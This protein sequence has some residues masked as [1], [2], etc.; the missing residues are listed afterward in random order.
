MHL[1]DNNAMIHDN[2]DDNFDRLYKVRPV[3]DHFNAV[4]SS[5]IPFARD[6]SVDENICATK[7]KHTIRQYNPKKPHKWGFKLYMLCGTVGFIYNS[8]IHS[9]QENESRFR[10]PNECDLGASSNVV[11]RMVRPVP[12]RR[13]HRFFL[14]TILAVCL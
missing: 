3:I 2:N 7:L 9:G 14:T 1:N 13:N 5:I 12:R 6:T 10:P 11:L 4:S 8:E